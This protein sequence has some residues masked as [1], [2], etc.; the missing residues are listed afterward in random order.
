MVK[1][2]DTCKYELRD[3]KEMP[4]CDCVGGSDG[5]HSEWV[6]AGE[7]SAEPETPPTTKT[8]TSDD[9]GAFFAELQAAEYK[10]WVGKNKDY[11]DHEGQGKGNTFA[12]F[13]VIAEELGTTAEQIAWVYLRKQLQAL[14][15]YV[16]H[17]KLETEP[18]MNRIIDARN[19]L[20]IIGGIARRKGDL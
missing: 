3:W 7:K 20:A 15:R 17:G 4:C 5:D 14:L 6:Y 2:C 8:F 19:F 1:D 12:N 13:D 16:K 18:L 9:M 11:A 10:L